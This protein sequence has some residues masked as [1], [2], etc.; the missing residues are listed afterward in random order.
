MNKKDIV[1]KI[2]NELIKDITSAVVS[3]FEKIGGILTYGIPEFRLPK[4]IVNKTIE[5]IFI[6]DKIG[7]RWYEWVPSIHCLNR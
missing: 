5:N 4:E 3:A 1:I 6:S 2:G 7:T